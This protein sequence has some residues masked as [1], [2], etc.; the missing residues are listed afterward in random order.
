[1]GYNIWHW[2]TAHQTRSGPR[3]TRLRLPPSLVV[4]R[5]RYHTHLGSFRQFSNGFSQLNHPRPHEIPKI[6]LVG[7]EIWGNANS[8]I[9]C[10]IQ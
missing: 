2:Q 8:I 3:L 10:I 7:N 9:Y 6:L 4:L 5:H 1:M